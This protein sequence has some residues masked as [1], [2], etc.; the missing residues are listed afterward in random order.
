VCH[1]APF[2][3]DDGAERKSQGITNYPVTEITL[4]L[5]SVMAIHLLGF[6]TFHKKTNVNLMLVLKKKSM[7]HLSH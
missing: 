2:C 5:G 7:D 1:D 3:P 4:N 6:Q